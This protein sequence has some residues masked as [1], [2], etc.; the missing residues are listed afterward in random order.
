MTAAPGTSLAGKVMRSGVPPAGTVWGTTLPGAAELEAA[1]FGADE[2][3]GMGFALG[4]V[5]EDATVASS[6]ST[7]ITSVELFLAP[8]SAE[9]DISTLKVVSPLRSFLRLSSA[10]G[11]RS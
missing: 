8:A 9:L 6:M 4:G 5:V 2:D 10:A 3:F 11:S 7:S 1:A